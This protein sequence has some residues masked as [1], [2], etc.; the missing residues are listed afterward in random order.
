MQ[1]R[2]FAPRA[3]GCFALNSA[4]IDTFAGHAAQRQLLAQSIATKCKPVCQ[5][6]K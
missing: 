5:K 6:A 2:P 3:P 1:N 4:F